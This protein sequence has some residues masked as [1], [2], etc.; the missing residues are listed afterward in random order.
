MYLNVSSFISIADRQTDR[1]TLSFIYIDFAKFQLRNSSLVLSVGVD[2]CRT[3][4]F[5]LNLFAFQFLMKP[6]NNV[7]I[8]NLSLQKVFAKAVDINLCNE[9][10]VFA[11]D[12]CQLMHCMQF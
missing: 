12:M 6:V 1:Q 3:F 11:I 8:D 2:K 7:L 5:V 10:S 4:F 9:A